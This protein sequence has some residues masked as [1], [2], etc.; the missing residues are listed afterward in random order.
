VRTLGEDVEYQL[1]A[2]DDAQVRTASNPAHLGGSQVSVK[3]ESFHVELDSANHH[4]LELTSAQDEPWI[5]LL[6]QLNDLVNDFHPCSSCQAPKLRKSRMRAACATMS[7][8][9]SM[10]EDGPPVL[11]FHRSG[12]RLMGELC[13]EGRDQITKVGLGLAVGK[14][15]G[16]GVRWIARVVD[17]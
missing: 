16:N 1:C 13:F 9:C 8:P 12:A 3:N 11:R 10:D 7:L 15:V 2:I 4:F 6:A 14:R 17:W 5:D